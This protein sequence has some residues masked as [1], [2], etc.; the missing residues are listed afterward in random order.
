V[1]VSRQGV[2]R[3]EG[4]RVC[5]ERA[6]EFENRAAARGAAAGQARR[7]AGVSLIKRVVHV[8]A[9]QTRR[10]DTRR[11]DKKRHKKT[12][13]KKAESVC[14]GP[15]A[16]KIARPALGLPSMLPSL[17]PAPAPGLPAHGL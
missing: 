1:S 8:V 10:Q 2:G 15:R 4:V 13:S 7:E 14:R 6:R 16:A 5:V 17:L 9:G 3:T 11:Q 12:A